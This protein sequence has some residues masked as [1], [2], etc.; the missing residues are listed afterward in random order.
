[1]R[2]LLLVGGMLG[3][4]WPASVQAE[5]IVLG[6]GEF[7]IDFG[8]V[9]SPGPMHFYMQIGPATSITGPI[10]FDLRLNPTDVGTT[11]TADRSTDADF[12]DFAGWLT[13]GSNDELRLG[14]HFGPNDSDGAGHS[15][16]E[17]G[18]FRMAPGIT[19]SMIDSLLLSFDDLRFLPTG[20]IIAHMNL[21]VQGANTA[22]VPEPATLLMLGGGLAAVLRSRR[23]RARKSA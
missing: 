1:M 8:T 7:G 21:T 10:L 2:R 14:F 4:L 3:V 20:E 12:G 23:L 19:A 11:F 5:P 15:I 9:T 18:V 6:T 13:N 16:A 17:Q 22:P